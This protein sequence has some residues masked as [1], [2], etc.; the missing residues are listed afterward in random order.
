MTNL[1]RKA[2]NEALFRE[3][4]DRIEEAAT[5]FHVP[6]EAEFVCECGQGDCT[7][8]M[9]LTL[10]EYER[11]RSH[12]KRFAILPG[13]EMPEIERVVEQTDRYAVVEKIGAAGRMVEALDPRD[14]N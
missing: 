2:K 11:V 5:A 7:R 4:N 12:G 3:V 10:R 13:H 6:D 9:S 8:M 1:Q 14:E